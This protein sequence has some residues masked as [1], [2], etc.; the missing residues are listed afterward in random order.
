MLLPVVSLTAAWLAI[1]GNPF[2]IA[3]V[4]PRSPAVQVR[5]PR[6][7]PVIGEAGLTADAAALARYI[8]IKYPM[9]DKIGGVRPDRL[10]DHPSGHA[11]DIM[12]GTDIWLGDRI[13]ADLMARA[14]QFHIRYL[15]WRETYRNPSGAV[16]FMADRG[17]LTA[18]HYDH[19]HVT[20]N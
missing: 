4:A 13:M 3:S 17:S 5:P 6:I 10:P 16:R 12:V 7:P 11:I 8:Q 9:V 2:M 18:N 1:V 19:V 14:S 15:I 20:V